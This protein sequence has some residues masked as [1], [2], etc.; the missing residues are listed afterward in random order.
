[1]AI[2]V[3]AESQAERS[4]AKHRPLQGVR[5]IDVTSVLM[6]PAAT[7]IL[8]DYGAD[9]VKV[10]SPGGDIMRHAGE[11]RHEGMGHVYLHAN[12]NKRSIVI[13]LKKPGGREALLELAGTADMFV[14]NVRPSAMARLG[15][16]YAAL[17]A[18]NP[19]II[20]VALVGFDQQGPYAALPAMDD[21]IQGA[22]GIAGLQATYNQGPPGYVPLVIVDRICAVNAAQVILAALFMRERTGRGQHIE[23][24]MFETIVQ[25]VLG[26]HLGG[27]TF[28]PPA[29]PM[30]YTRLL[31]PHR[32]PFK[33]RDG[34]IAL[35][36]YTDRHWQQFFEVI[37]QPDKFTDDSR[38][39]TAAMRGKHHDITYAMLTEC[40]LERTTAEWVEVLQRRD[41]PCL[42]LHDLR[43]VLSDPHL[44]AIDFFTMMDHPSEGRVRT[45]RVASTWSDAELSIQRHAPRVGEQSI[46]IL[47]EAGF[48]E[49]R[50]ERLLTE[51]A[52]VQAPG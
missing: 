46:E 51:D 19:R 45:M 35:I 20:Y 33:T 52:V 14:H 15:L 13:D 9:V 6:G 10:E 21:V 22:S 32:R 40:L 41:I 2:D 38:F 11:M 44:A 1:M 25:I 42:P 3:A 18:V 8:A 37:G 7:Q 29:G 5:V 34:Y 39:T 30:G 23:V 12:R 49:E 16:D 17:A 24:P 26:D 47:R 50:I 27:E 31:T 4:L 28:D 48:S 36:V 43:G